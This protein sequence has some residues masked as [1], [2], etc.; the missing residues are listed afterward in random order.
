MG[1]FFILF[2]FKI[3]I[4]ATTLS[5]NIMFILMVTGILSLVLGGVIFVP[6]FLNMCLGNIGGFLLYPRR[7]MKKAPPTLSIAKSKRA[8]GAFKDALE[9]LEN[10]ETEYPEVLQ[11]YIDMI[12]ILI[13]DLHD[14]KQAD[15][16]YLRGIQVLSDNDRLVLTDMYNAL[17]SHLIPATV[18]RVKESLEDAHAN[19][20]KRP[21]QNRKY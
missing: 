12:D 9:H 21:Y 5:G 8:S 4:V 14:A 15:M 17:K 18:H 1:G 16:V 10:L 2:G 13:V 7:E 11:I 20:P 19:R 3:I 6:I